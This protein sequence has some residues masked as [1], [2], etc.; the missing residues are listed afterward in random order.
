MPFAFFLITLTSSIADDCNNNVLL[1]E[2][3]KA[4]FKIR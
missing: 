3:N 1:I 4:Y 2:N